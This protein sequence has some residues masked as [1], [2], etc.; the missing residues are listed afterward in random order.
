MTL[1]RFS[2]AAFLA[3]MLS[4]LVVSSASAQAAL[5]FKAYGT[6]LIPGQT[7]EAFNG[8]KSV[9]KTTVDAAG[10]WIIDIL[11][12]LAANGD[13]ITFTRDGQPTSARVTFSN[14]QFTPP[15][16]LLLTVTAGSTLPPSTGAGTGTP[17]GTPVGGNPATY[18]VESGD[19]LYGLALR[20]GTTSG[21][22]AQLNGITD[23]SLV[24]IGQV[25]KVPGAPASAP[26]S[27]SGSTDTPATYIV[28]TGD[29]LSG[30]AVRWGTT[31]EAIAALNGITD[32]SRLRIREVLKVPGGSG[33]SGVPPAASGSGT[34]TVVAGDNLST[35]AEVW[36]T[37]VASIAALNG[38]SD[39]GALQIG[40]VLK[41]P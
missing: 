17:A 14:G 31:V 27:S 5:P 9:G 39:P 37:T 7:I 13:V 28:A 23:P 6:S 16:G 24:R 8:T 33:S 11:P 36:G 34:Y 4:V 38:L 3:V 30:L 26:G 22:I 10:N 2:V 19:T 1:P 25:L 40:Q 29:T 12:E 20:W 32:P 18:T 21:A 41:R 15:P 35:L